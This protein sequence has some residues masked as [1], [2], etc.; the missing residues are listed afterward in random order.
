LSLQAKRERSRKAFSTAWFVI[1]AIQTF[2]YR[3]PTMAAFSRARQLQRLI[4]RIE[5]LIA[6]GVA[7]SSR[8]TTYR[9]AI[10]IAG[11]I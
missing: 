9:L 7:V 2:A 8:F 4:G 5:R 10:F 6:G 1:D 3:Q 11:V